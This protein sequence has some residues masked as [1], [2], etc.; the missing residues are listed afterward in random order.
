MKQITHIQHVVLFFLALAVLSCKGTIA[1]TTDVL[2]SLNPDESLA[3]VFEI[4]LKATVNHNDEFRI[5]YTAKG[6]TEFSENQVIRVKIVGLSEEQTIIYKFPL[7]IYPSNLRFDFGLNSNQQTTGINAM[8]FID[9]QQKKVIDGKN[10]LEY[11]SILYGTGKFDKNAKQLQRLNE[12]GLSP[13]II[14]KKKLIK[15]IFHNQ[16]DQTQN[17]NQS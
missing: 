7:G 17:V 12:Q 1:T 2:S 13:I 4:Q 5:Y 14:A 10:L 6:T 9:G 16:K 11:F 15:Q 8:I 3:E